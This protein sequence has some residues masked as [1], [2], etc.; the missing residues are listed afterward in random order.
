[1]PLR[2]VLFLTYYFPPSGGPGVQRAL[3]FVRYLPDFGWLPTVLTVRPE[4]AAYPALDPALAAEVPAAVPV[5]RT[6]A[7][8]PYA[9]YARLQGKTKAE[10]VSVGFL[11]E[12]EA[13]WQQRL[14]RWVRANLFLPDARVGWVPY[15]VARGRRLLAEEAFDAVFS[16]GPPHSTHLAA[17]VLAA[18]SG[19]PWV[20]DF[21]D[22]WTDID[23]ADQLPTTALARAVD[24]ALERA[25]LRRATA[26][27][28][29]TPAWRDDLARRVPAAYH[30][31]RNGFD[32]ADFGPPPPVP[33]DVF[34]LTYVGNLNAARNPEALWQAL[35]RLEAPTRLPHLRVRL[36]GSV[37]PVA[38]EAAARWGVEGLVEAEAYVPHGEAVR[39]MQEAAL[40]L[41]VINRSGN[42]QGVVPGKVYEYVASGRPVLALGPHGGDAEAVLHEA[43]AG[44]LFDYDDAAGVADFVAAHYAAWAAGAP[45]TGAPAARAERFS[46]RGQTQALAALLDELTPK[47]PNDRSAQ[48]AP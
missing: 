35:A 28:V 17:L 40:L 46:R 21:R 20:A 26:V 43:R 18:R 48:H 3:K 16:T 37:D 36:V 5:E 27:T 7:W 25:V 4:A 29:V 6:A 39:L 45:A 11:G 30:M 19:L 47:E 12:A 31:L 13:T 23:Y 42:R 9:L 44:R 22:P 14:A 10:T 33:R 41:L 32:P 1:M 34:R 15:A 24:A 2:R 8:D 38:L